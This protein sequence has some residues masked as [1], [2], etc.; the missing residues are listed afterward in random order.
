MMKR[1]S[2]LLKRRQNRKISSSAS[3]GT[4]REDFALPPSPEPQLQASYHRSCK[5]LTL[6]P[7]I[8]AYCN[9]QLIGLLISGSSTPEGLQNAWNEILFDY[10]G[11]FKTEQ[12]DYIF[13]LQREIG[14]LQHHVAYVE[15]SIILLTHRYDDDVVKELVSMGY[16]IPEFTDENYQQSLSRITSLAKSK[17]F[18]L[19]NLVD[20]Y[21]R[22]SKTSEGKKQTEEEFIRTVAMLSKYQGYH[23]DRKTTMVFDFVQIFNNYLTEMSAKEKLYEYARGSH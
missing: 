23:V 11:L 2:I 12:S 14:I 4:N 7:F 18:E 6:E 17:V 10:A 3:T 21:N 5:T 8:Q 22:L 9:N 1:L 20:E 19:S 13:Q 16:T 15:Y